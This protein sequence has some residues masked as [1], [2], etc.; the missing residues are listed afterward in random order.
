M[1][2][3]MNDQI[4]EFRIPE[5]RKL[6]IRSAEVQAPAVSNPELLVLLF[7]VPKKRIPEVRMPEVRMKRKR[8]ER[9]KNLSRSATTEITKQ[10][11]IT[12]AG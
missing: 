5:S 1:M 6:V 9:M 4:P 11:T 10:L 7:P 3:T 2:R 12:F 8:S